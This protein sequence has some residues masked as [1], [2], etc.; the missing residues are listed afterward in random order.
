MTH[1]L[2]VPRLLLAAALLW[3]SAAQAQEPL[4]EMG[5]GFGGLQYPHYRGSAESEL[6]PLPIPYYVYRGDRLR[7]D[8]DGLRSL[9]F[10]SD[11]MEINFSGDGAFPV[12][13]DD[14]ARED[15]DDLAP[16][17]EVGPSLN[18]AL[19]QRRGDARYLELRL[20]VRSAFSVDSG[21]RIDQEGW[22]FAPSIYWVDNEAG[23]SGQWRRTAAIG[24]IFAD[25]DFHDYFYSVP[26]ADAT[27]GR[28]SFQAGGGYSGSR[29]TFSSA[30]RFE[31]LWLG[32]FLRY[33]N[34]EGVAFDDS[35]L[36]ERDHALLFGFG[37]SWV[38][39]ESERRVPRRR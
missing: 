29:L 9:L 12:N 17:I 7:A 1:T 6:I 26:E 19:W 31:R 32:G 3:A 20:P 28:P 18:I 39:A 8:R 4:W 37:F 34:L 35:P 15:M 10:E 11:R 2:T 16:L 21:P 33:D 14:N 24:P 25:R 23:Y 36:V 38:F 27:T 30:R 5:I 22:T 13:D